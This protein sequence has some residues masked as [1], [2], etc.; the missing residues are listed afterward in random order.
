MSLQSVVAGIPRT[1]GGLR[2]DQVKQ[3]IITTPSGSCRL[4]WLSPARCSIPDTRDFMEARRQEQKLS[5]RRGAS[6]SG[7]G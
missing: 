5:S 7:K 1:L 6:S 2:E 4:N 3:W